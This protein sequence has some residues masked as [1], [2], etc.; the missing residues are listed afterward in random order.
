MTVSITG[1]VTRIVLL[2]A[3]GPSRVGLVETLDEVVREDVVVIL[4][5]HQHSGGQHDQ[6]EGRGHP[7]PDQAL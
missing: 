2:S 4:G 3:S 1:T 7:G 6:Q 5:L